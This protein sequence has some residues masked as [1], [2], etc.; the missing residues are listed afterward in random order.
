MSYCLFI[1]CLV[2]V[3]TLMPPLDPPNRPTYWD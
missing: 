2:L 1:L 3:I